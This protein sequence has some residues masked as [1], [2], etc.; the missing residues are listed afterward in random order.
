MEIYEIEQTLLGKLIVNSQLLDKYSNLLHEDL[1]ET[2]FSKSV[3]HA[4][5]K[6]KDKNIPIDILSIAKNIK[7]KDVALN[8]SFMT[9]LAFDFTE[10][11]TCIGILTEEFQKRT[12]KGIVHNVHNRLS[13]QEELELII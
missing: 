3:Y 1:F 6:L 11:I 10:V 4:I 9:D 2:P 5:C 8:L 12:L 13:D 7:G